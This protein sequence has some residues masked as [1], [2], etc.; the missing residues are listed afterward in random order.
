M[1]KKLLKNYF[2]TTLYQLLYAILPL[3]TIPYKTRVLGSENLGIYSY[4]FSVMQ[5]IVSI[6]TLGLSFYGRR[7]IAYK[8]N[9]Y[10]RSKLLYELLILKAIIFSIVTVPFYMIIGI[11]SKYVIFYLIILPD[12]IMNIFDIVWF[13]QG[14]E[15]FK[16]ICLVNFVTRI[17]NVIFIFLF[18]KTQSDLINYVII[19]VIFD[20]ITIILF[21]VQIHKYIQRVPLKEL[22]PYKHLK[23]CI[24]LF[25]P[26]VCIQIYTICDKLMLGNLQSNINEVGFYEYSYKLIQILISIISAISLVII[27]SISKE[28]INNNKEKIKEYINNSINFVIFLS[29]PLSFGIIAI[30]YGMVNIIFGQEFI[31]MNILIQILA[32]TILPINIT[33]IIGDSYMISTKQEKKFTLIIAIGTIFNL[34][35]NLL[36]INKYNSIGVTISTSLTEILILFI[37]IPIIKKLINIKETIF[38]FIKYLLCSITMFLVVYTIGYFGISITTLIIQI[39]SGIII[40]LILLIMLKDKMLNDLINKIMKR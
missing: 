35:L 19:T 25:L 8:N 13:Y 20:I 14:L 21:I 34:M 1:N 33:T 28:F 2:Y 11:H 12:I 26:Q 10:E 15:E 22:N 39:I 9:K 23:A 29:L 7:E 40:Y 17:L 4:V 27:P 36:L 37:E 30:S 6:G 38:N 16:K 24:I 18:V 32:V 5:Y 3:V 31:K